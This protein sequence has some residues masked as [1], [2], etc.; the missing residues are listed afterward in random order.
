[1]NIPRIL[2][3]L[4][5]AAIAAGCASQLRTSVT[6][7][8]QLPPPSSQSFIVVAADEQ[9][10]GSLELQEYAAVVARELTAIGFVPAGAADPDLIVKLDYGVSPPREKTRREGG[11]APFYGSAFFGSWPAFGPYWYYPHGFTRWGFGFS[12][13]PYEYSYTVFD[14]MAAVSI[15]KNGGPVIFEGRAGTTTR[16]ANLPATVPPLIRAL[17]TG[18]PGRSGE[19][20]TIKVPLE[21]K[22]GY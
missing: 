7:F 13:Y 8:H 16:K 17:F 15:E 12:Y 9:R 11:Y 1:M 2:L 19:T 22:G 3:V 4:V 6:R 5:A 14:I 18:F 10:A 20:V 21:E